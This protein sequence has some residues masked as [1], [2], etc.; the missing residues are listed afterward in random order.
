M[1]I[2]ALCILLGLLFTL[3]HCIKPRR[4][5]DENYLSWNQPGG[6][7]PSNKRAPHLHKE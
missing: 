2:G 3:R 5:G 1:S 4:L 6:G 7:L